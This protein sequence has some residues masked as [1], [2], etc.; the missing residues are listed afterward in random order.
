MYVSCSAKRFGHAI[1][2][3]GATSTKT[4]PGTVTLTGVNTYTGLTTV[5]AGS[6]TMALNNA[7]KAGNDVQVSGGTLDLN[8]FAGTVVRNVSGTAIIGY[9]YR[10]IA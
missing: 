5:N 4:G 6:A 9:A 2:G 10:E 1:H 8:G 3:S 7:I